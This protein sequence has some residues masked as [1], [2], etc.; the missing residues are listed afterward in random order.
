MS[1]EKM[2]QEYLQQTERGI[3]YHSS[4]GNE[5]SD[6]IIVPIRFI[7]F[8]LCLQTSFNEGGDGPPFYGG[9]RGGDDNGPGNHFCVRTG[10]RGDS[11]EVAP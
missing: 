10:P 4:N 5:L 11:F 3:S 2:R 7:D 1:I 6:I 9:Y 8:S